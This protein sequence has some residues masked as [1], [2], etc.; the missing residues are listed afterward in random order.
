M[1]S[2][3]RMG[4]L[5]PMISDRRMGWLRPVISDRRMGWLLPVI[6]DRRMGWLPSPGAACGESLACPLDCVPSR[7]SAR[8]L[9][10]RTP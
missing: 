5:R 9:D 2:D 6:S 10:L 1:I 3:R 4:W 8:L 7:S